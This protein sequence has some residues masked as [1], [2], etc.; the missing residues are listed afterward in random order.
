MAG[1]P[2]GLDHLIVQ[3]GGGALASSCIQAFHEAAALGAL[4]RIPRI[5]TVQT[6][7]AHPLERAYERVRAMLSAEP[8]PEAVHEAMAQAASHRSAFM[9]PWDEQPASA[10]TGILDDETYDWRAVVEGMLT[11]GGLPL[12]VGSRPDRGQPSSNVTYR[13][14]R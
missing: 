13:D 7:G 12:V 11:T 5:H 8:S 1:V 10:A 4:A 14:R 2:D 9:Q 6:V 3:V